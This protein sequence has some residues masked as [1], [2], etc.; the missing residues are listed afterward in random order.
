[1]SK[2]KAFNDDERKKLIRGIHHYIRKYHSGK[3]T[4]DTLKT[5]FQWV[6]LDKLGRPQY[7]LSNWVL[8]AFG[9]NKNL[10]IKRPVPV[11]KG[12]NDGA[13]QWGKPIR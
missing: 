1:M 5:A 2:Y 9:V 8:V 3:V 4:E 11:I 7:N 12:I 10:T 6:S 13:D